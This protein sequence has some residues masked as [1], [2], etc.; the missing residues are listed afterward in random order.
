MGRLFLVSAIVR[1][2]DSEWKVLL[3]RGDETV[4]AKKRCARRGECGVES[5][6]LYSTLACPAGI[7]MRFV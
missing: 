4:A 3:Q 1:K 7:S 2:M 6:G 5:K